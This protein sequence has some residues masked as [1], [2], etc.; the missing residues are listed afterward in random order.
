MAENY[1]EV[2]QTIAKQVIQACKSTAKQSVKE[3]TIQPTQITGEISAAKI[4]NLDLVVQRVARIV[5]DEAEIDGANIRDASISDA[6]IVGLTANKI[7]T[8]TLD[9]SNITVTNLKAESITTG[10]LEYAVIPSLDDDH[11]LDGAITGSKVENGA[12]TEDKVEDGAITENK[13]KNGAI[14]TAKV[15]DGAI[16]G[17][18]IV[19]GAITTDKIVAGAIDAG[20]ITAGAITT[21]K[22]NAD[23]CEN[24]DISANKS[25]S[26]TYTSKTDFDAYQTG[27]KKYQRFT[28]D[29]LE[30]GKLDDEG[31]GFKANFTANKLSFYEDNNE[32]AYISNQKMFITQAQVTDGL[33][34]GG[35]DAGG[36]YSFVT[37]KTGMALRWRK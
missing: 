21:D 6:K 30:I 4:R 25:L 15:V 11:I 13:V 3:T 36:A 33:M 12:I 10:T 7:R 5:I 32:V 28:E 1:S 2:V 18:K 34:V 35:E 17:D 20:C 31:N 27:V 9:A 22:I 16:T 14:T 23:V 26:I 37:T 24:L 29:G 19:A 8:G